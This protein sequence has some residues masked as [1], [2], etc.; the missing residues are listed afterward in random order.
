M[1]CT[2][3]S[4]IKDLKSLGLQQGDTV[5]VHCSVSQIGWVSGGP[6][7]VVRALLE[8][9][10][11]QGTLVV[12]TH[13]IDNSDPAT[14]TEPRYQTVPE[15]WWA[16]IRESLP[17]YDP[18][19][20]RSRRMGVVPEIVRTWPTA[21]RSAHPQTS[22]AAIGAKAS[23]ITA[24]HRINCRMGEHSPLARLEEAKAKVLLLGV[25]FNKCTAFHLAEYRSETAPIVPCSF[26]CTLGGKREWVTVE[27]RSWDGAP[28]F[29]A[30]G[31]EF[32][33][34][35]GDLVRKGNVGKAS[36]LVFPVAES[37]AFAAEWLR[38]AK[39]INN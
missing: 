26:A 33:Q 7:T 34:Q 31:E 18:K 21:L 16:A 37:V 23:H 8:C 4:L 5:M 3:S 22:F 10:G 35:H 28:N 20:T 29:V 27:D 9:L 15:D 6:E 39:Q 25:G 36:C 2:V 24:D 13:T 38:R 17:P 11:P 14:W 1:L 19:T 30:I 12:P 32:E